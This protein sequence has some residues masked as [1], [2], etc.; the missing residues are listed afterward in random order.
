MAI[1]RLALQEVVE[2]GVG[3]LVLKYVM[4]PTDTGALTIFSPLV[5]IGIW[6]PAVMASELPTVPRSAL[7]M[8]VK[9]EVGVPLVVSVSQIGRAHV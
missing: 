3:V 5:L 6:H 2:A 7:V 4:P 8:A 9:A 1:P